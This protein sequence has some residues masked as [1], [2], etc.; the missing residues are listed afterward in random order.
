MFYSSV[1]QI[2][3]RLF[4]VLASRLASDSVQYRWFYGLAIWSDR[5]RQSVVLACEFSLIKLMI[6]VREISPP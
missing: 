2:A 4:V 6:V 3:V 5:L 1:H